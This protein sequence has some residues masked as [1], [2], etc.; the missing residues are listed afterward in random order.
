MTASA[1]IE[2][3]ATDGGLF[4]SGFERLRQRPLVTPDGHAPSAILE[5][6]HAGDEVDARDRRYRRSLAAA[7]LLA[8]ALALLVTIALLGDGGLRAASLGV[9]PLAVGLPKLHGLYDRDELLIRKT[10]MD[11][12]PQ[13]FQLATLCTLI[14]WLAHGSIVA[15]GL[16]S[17]QVLVLWGGLFVFTLV[18]RRFARML[19]G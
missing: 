11:E 7:D 3:S 13:I 9:L 17:A 18:G 19:A 6:N 8:T 12:A 5:G 4:Q 16:S 1:V 14:F 10:T 15:G 2:A